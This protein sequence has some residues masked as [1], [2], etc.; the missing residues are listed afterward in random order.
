MLASSCWS[1]PI[2]S[3][4]ITVT[5]IRNSGPISTSCTLCLESP[6]GAFWEKNESY[7]NNSRANTCSVIAD[8]YK[9]WKYY[10]WCIYEHAVIP[11]THMARIINVYHQVWRTGT[12]LASI[13]SLALFNSQDHRHLSEVRVNQ[14]NSGAC[15]GRAECLIK[16]IINRKVGRMLPGAFGSAGSFVPPQGKSLDRLLL[17][18]AVIELVQTSSASTG[19]KTKKNKHVYCWDKLKI[20]CCFFLVCFFFFFSNWWIGV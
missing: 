13:I 8:F 17:V 20:G 3:I 16:S 5:V 14:F 4:I 2:S 1:S 19:K 7:Y 18:M 12:A 10:L 9:Q 6:Q 11:Y 15:R